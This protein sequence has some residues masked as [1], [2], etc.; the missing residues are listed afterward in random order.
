MKILSCDIVDNQAS[1]LNSLTDIYIIH[2]EVNDL[3]NQASDMITTIMDSSW[4]SRLSPVDKLSYEAR[5]KRTISKLVDDVFKKI[6]DSVTVDFGEYMV[7]MSAQ[8][9]LET[10]L[11]HFKL[12]LAELFKEKMTG[13][14]GFDFHTQS[15]TTLV[16]FGEAKYS[17]NNSPYAN[18]LAQIAEFITLEKDVAELTDLS[19]F[20]SEE[21]ITN[22]LKD[23]KAYIAA[24]SVNAKDPKRIFNNVLTSEYITPLLNCSELYLI[25]VEVK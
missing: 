17:G 18:A 16:A 14:P 24:F 13:N 12:P 11:K 23:K 25:G 15:H 22:A 2:V 19:K 9:A 10:S 6:A 8:A 7:S 4:I 21:A 1:D 3:S 5:A 20:I